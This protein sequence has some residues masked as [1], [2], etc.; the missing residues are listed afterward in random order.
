[1]MVGTKIKSA[2]Q[3]QQLSQAEVSQKAGLQRCQISD[4]EHDKIDLQHIHWGTIQK[5]CK[6]LDL[7]PYDFMES[8]S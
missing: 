6:V 2:R 4:L 3:K 1:M 5:L 7:T 8:V